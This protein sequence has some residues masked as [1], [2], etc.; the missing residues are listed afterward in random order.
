M[1]NSIAGTLKWRNQDICIFFEKKGQSI[2]DLRQNTVVMRSQEKNP[3]NC[4]ENTASKMPY[5]FQNKNYEVFRKK[6][7]TNLIMLNLEI[8]VRKFLEKM[9][10]SQKKNGRF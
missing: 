4:P 7:F 8:R 3:N 6:Y 1:H 5:F 9:V 2:W 10:G